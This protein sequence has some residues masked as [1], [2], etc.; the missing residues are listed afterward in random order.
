MAVVEG[1]V[2]RTWDSGFA[3]FRFSGVSCGV[4]RVLGRVT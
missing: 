1:C 4:T 2:G 3:G